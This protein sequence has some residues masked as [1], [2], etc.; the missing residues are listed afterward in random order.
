VASFI[1]YIVGCFFTVNILK[2]L[3]SEKTTHNIIN[4][5]YHIN[6]YRPNINN[7][8]HS[9]IPSLEITTL[10]LIPWFS[11]LMFSLSLIIIIIIT[12]SNNNKNK[13]MINKININE[14]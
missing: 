11:V 14:R 4:E 2:Y 9:T 1:Y 3:Y 5:G 8:L 10:S 12:L 6:F 13:G 7:L